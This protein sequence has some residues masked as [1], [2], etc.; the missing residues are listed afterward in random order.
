MKIDWLPIGSV[1]ILRGG[2][3]HPVMIYGRKQVRLNERGLAEHFDY[4]GCLFPEG[5]I[6]PHNNFLFNKEQVEQ[7]LFIGYQNDQ[8]MV[9]S[10]RLDNYQAP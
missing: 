9:I 4:T 7:V 3:S 6:D 5:N 10:E 1:V 8:E 2:G